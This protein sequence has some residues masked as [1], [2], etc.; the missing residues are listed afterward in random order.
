MNKDHFIWSNGIQEKNKNNIFRNRNIEILKDLPNHKDITNIFIKDDCVLIIGGGKLYKQGFFKWETVPENV[1]YNAIKEVLIKKDPKDTHPA[2][3][4]CSIGDSHVLIQ[5]VSGFVYSWGDNYYGQL[6]QG[7]YFLPYSNEP[8]VILL[9]QSNAISAPKK[10]STSLVQ[11]PAAKTEPAHRI[12]AY[13]N[14]SFVIDVNK[15]LWVWGSCDLLGGIFTT[16]RFKPEKILEKYVIENFKIIEDRII[17]ETV[18]EV[19]EQQHEEQIFEEDVS[20][21]PNQTASQ[22]QLSKIE[23]DEEK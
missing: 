5:T 10:L 3:L 14:T 13:R 6:G 8:S 12:Y 1:Y 15:K 23:N 2:A 9:K 19:V 18:C 22:N 20:K 4:F 7:K 21:T 16:N 11:E 17:M